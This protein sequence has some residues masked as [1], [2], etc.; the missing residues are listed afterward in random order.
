MADLTPHEQAAIALARRK[1]AN[2]R[3]TWVPVRGEPVGWH[4][5]A[6]PATGRVGQCLRRDGAWVQAPLGDD[7]VVLAYSV[8]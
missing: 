1:M 4:D 8:R 3:G 6:D 5:W 2:A 7:P